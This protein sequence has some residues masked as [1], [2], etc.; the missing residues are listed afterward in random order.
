MLCVLICFSGVLYI[1]SL[2]YGTIMRY[3]H[4][5]RVRETVS[6]LKKM[7]LFSTLSLVHN[8]LLM[9][10]NVC[11]RDRWEGMIREIQKVPSPQ[12]EGKHGKSR[13]A[14]G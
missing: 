2:L 5:W 11:G 12:M 8:P 7:N 4:I 13:R 9:L 14:H 10:V 1:P 3:F 6:P